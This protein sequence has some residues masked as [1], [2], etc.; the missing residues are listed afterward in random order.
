MFIVRP[1]LDKIDFRILTTLEQEGR[2]QNQQLAERVLLSPGACSQRLRRLEKAKLI[3]GF[4]ADIDLRRLCNAVSIFAVV[5]LAEQGSLKQNQFLKALEYIPEVVDCYEV[6]GDA[7]FIVKFD[8]ANLEDYHERVTELLS[9]P[10]FGVRK[11]ESHVI[12][13]HVNTLRRSNLLHLAAT[14]NA[15]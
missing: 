4:H 8:C 1:R 3:K 11:I 7:D 15:I 5:K 10:N 6:A 9:D 13:R 2:I 12:L 14:S